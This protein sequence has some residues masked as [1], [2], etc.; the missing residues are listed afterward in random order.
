MLADGTVLAKTGERGL[1]GELVGDGSVR[2]H[3][4][5][6][7]GRGAGE[8]WIAM[9]Q[10]Q[11]A[12]GALLVG[13]GEQV[14]LGDGGGIRGAGGMLRDGARQQRHGGGQSKQKMRRCVE[15][16]HAGKNPPT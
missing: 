10:R 7:L 12:R 5:G 4:L 3:R 14:L 9:Q 8:L 16:P 1:A 11:V 2:G 6:V 13:R 15:R